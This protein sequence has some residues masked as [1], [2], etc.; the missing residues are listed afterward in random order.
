MFEEILYGSAIILA[1]SCLVWFALKK[2][3]PTI[4]E[5]ISQ[6][7]AESARKEQDITARRTR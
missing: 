1:G 2:Y 7:E 5:K 4:D 3:Q 6:I